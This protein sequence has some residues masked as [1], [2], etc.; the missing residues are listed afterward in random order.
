MIDVSSVIP[1]FGLKK[2][3]WRLHKYVRILPD[4]YERVYLTFN[5][6]NIILISGLPR[7]IKLEIFESFKMHFI[8]FPCNSSFWRYNYLKSLLLPYHKRNR[9][10]M[11]SQYYSRFTLWILI[12]S[13]IEPQK[14][15][16]FSKQAYTSISARP[17]KLN[18][19]RLDI[20]SRSAL[21]SHLRDY[22][23]ER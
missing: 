4:K 20:R 6:T 13:C 8:S 17:G 1:T 9:Y 5:F 7:N 10:L 16:I 22:D 21:L 3:T 19:R 23:G 12:E 18:F 11:P 14:P 15:Q 2:I